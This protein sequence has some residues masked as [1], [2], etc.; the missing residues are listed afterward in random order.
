MSFRDTLL[1]GMMPGNVKIAVERVAEKSHGADVT[2]EQLQKC[3]D[4]V[5]HWDKAFEFFMAISSVDTA[6]SML[7]QLRFVYHPSADVKLLMS[8]DQISKV[9]QLHVE[10]YRFLQSYCQ[11]NKQ[12][13]I[14]AVG[15]KALAVMK[16]RQFIDKARSDIKVYGIELVRLKA[17]HEHH[18]FGSDVQS[19]AKEINYPTS[20]AS[21]GDGASL[22]AEAQSPQP[23]I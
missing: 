19:D 10:L 3:V 20:P 12:T 1:G 2:L 14:L 16:M 6:S 7:D 11:A 21:H 8:K 18:L 23:A 15:K 4:C 5:D 9:S 17:Q 22:Q 13:G